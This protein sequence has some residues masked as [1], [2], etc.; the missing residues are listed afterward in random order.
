MVQ[1]VGQ[2]SSRN[3]ID[4]LMQWQDFVIASTMMSSRSFQQ[5]GISQANMGGYLEVL[6]AEAGPM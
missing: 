1:A 5:A 3:T 6:A 4:Y 2:A